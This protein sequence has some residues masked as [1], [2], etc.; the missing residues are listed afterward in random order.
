MNKKEE[1]TTAGPHFSSR[2]LSKQIQLVFTA[3]I[4]LYLTRVALPAKVTVN[5]SEKSNSANYTTGNHITG[6]A[7]TTGD[8]SILESVRSVCILTRAGFGA[9]VEL[10]HITVP[11]LYVL[12]ARYINRQRFKLMRADGSDICFFFKIP[13]TL[14]KQYEQEILFFL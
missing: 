2:Q 10:S 4:F 12:Y 13:P 3:I 1:E 8:K 7:L 5:R 9:L 11:L 6:E 14:L